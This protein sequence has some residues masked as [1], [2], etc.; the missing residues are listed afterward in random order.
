MLDML[1]T[2]LGILLGSNPLDLG[3]M[4]GQIVCFDSVQVGISC[5]EQTTQF[6]SMAHHGHSDCLLDRLY[7]H[8]NLLLPSHILLLD[9]NG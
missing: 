9:E 5:P 6:E 8:V 3:H 1:M 7:V 4:L 2:L